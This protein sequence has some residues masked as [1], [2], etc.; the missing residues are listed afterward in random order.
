MRL[1]SV[2][3]RSV[4]A[5]LTV[6]ELPGHVRTQELQG[7][8]L[9]RLTSPRSL[10]LVAAHGAASRAARVLERVIARR[11]HAQ[12]RAAKRRMQLRH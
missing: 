10:E 4:R 7:R 12:S 1:F 3:W 9:L 5:G 6:A 11:V 8:S 2:N